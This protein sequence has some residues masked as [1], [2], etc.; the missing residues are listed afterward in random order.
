MDELKSIRKIVTPSETLLVVD[1]MTGQEALHIAEG[2][3]NAIELTGLIFTKMDGDARGGAA[4]SVRS[5]T[6]VPIKYLG[7]G[8]SVDALESFDPKS[9]CPREFWVWG[10]SSG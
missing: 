4:I 2:F 1:A 8:E 6:G 7:V 9:A 3:R 10:M 5:V